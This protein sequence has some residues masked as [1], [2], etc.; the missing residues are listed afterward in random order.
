MS[1]RFARR[2]QLPILTALA[3]FLLLLTPSAQAGHQFFRNGS[4]GGISITPDGVVNN[5]RIQ[6]RKM[7][8]AAM[9]KEVRN[10][11]GKM[12]NPTKLRKISLK[13]L[14]AA[15]EHAL[16][17]NLGRLPEEIRF[18]GG[19]QRIEYILVY[20]EHNDIVI[21]GYGEGWTVD[22]NANVVGITTGR[23]VLH[24]D[25]LLVALR[26][27]RQARTKGISV[28]IDPTQKGVVKLQRYLSKA[29][30]NRGVNPRRLEAGM[31]KAFGPQ[32]VKITG[33]S[34]QTRYARTLV[35]ADYRMKRLAMRLDKAPIKNFPSYL[36]MI[37]GKRIAGANSNP[38]WWLAPKYEP[39]VRSADGLTWQIKGQAIQAMTEQ[40]F[41]D[42]NGKVRQAKR[43]NTYAQ[44]WADTFT[45]R[46]T[47]LSA[48]DKV[49]NDLRNIMDMSVVAA[50]IDSNRLMERAG[51]S[52][53]LLTGANKAL[54]TR[55]WNAPK[56]VPPQ[57]S[58]LRSGRSWIVTASGGVQIE[59]WQVAAKN[60]KAD[61]SGIRK[62]S[63]NK[64]KSWWWN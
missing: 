45:K 3:A 32:I 53:P 54:K 4:V 26:T 21:A 25:D 12:Q 10:A 46:F 7:L 40:E 9:K 42:S 39:L 64:A 30:S 20:P 23:P 31:R 49:F 11:D 2:S 5:F 36:D 44:K 59:S 6:S 22:G 18:L 13:G 56:T 14:E 60:V 34:A 16:K 62:A 29:R 15:I 8:L 27:V 57:C 28:S 48:K 33:V 43:K 51:C 24:L 52:L 58:F 50:V 55:V 19:L 41:V 38:R 35:A 63:A 47:E 17:N 1:S 37:R 61:M